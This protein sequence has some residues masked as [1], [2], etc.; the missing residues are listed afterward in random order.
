MTKS[1]FSLAAIV[2]LCLA[3][4]AP[5]T[6]INYPNDAGVI[7]VT[8]P[9][10]GL[11]PV[12]PNDGIDD[13]ANINAILAAYNYETL[14][15]EETHILA[16]WVIYFPAGTYNVSGTLLAPACSV[17]FSGAGVGATIIKLTNNTFTSAY[18]NND[19]VPSPLIQLGKKNIPNNPSLGGPAGSYANFVRNL[20]L[21]LGNNPGAAGIFTALSNMGQ[22]Y[23]VEI[24]AANASVGLLTY[25]RAGTGLI[26]NVSIEGCDYGIR[27]YWEADVSAANRY[28]TF[29]GDPTDDGLVFED[30]TIAN[31]K[32]SAIHDRARFFVMRNLTISAAP[33]TSGPAI[34]LGFSKNAAQLHV[35]GLN[36]AGNSSYPGIQITHDD[37]YLVLRDASITGC[38]KAIGYASPATGTDVTATD[39]DHYST[40]STH[41]KYRAFNKLT[42][43]LP[44]LETPVYTPPP[45]ITGNW[46]KTTMSPSNSGTANATA[47]QNDINACSTPVLYIPAGYYEMEGTIN[48]D[49]SNLKMIKGFFP[50]LWGKGATFN[51][52]DADGF[53]TIEDMVIKA[54][55]K[56]NQDMGKPL[57][58]RNIGVAPQIV[59][60]TGGRGDIFL[61]NIGAHPRIAVQG[62]IRLFARQLNREHKGLT[63]DGAVVWCLGDNIES[64]GD[65][66]TRPWKTINGGVSEILGAMFDATTP[67]ALAGTAINYLFEIDGAKSRLSVAG[68]GNYKI[69]QNKGWDLLLADK[70]G[71]DY[72]IGNRYDNSGSYVGSDYFNTTYAGHSFGE[73]IL[74]PF[75]VDR[76]NLAFYPMEDGSGPSE[77]SYCSISSVT[78]SALAKGADHFGFNAPTTVTPEMFRNVYTPDLYNTSLGL[79]D[80]AKDYAT[81]SVTPNAGYTMNIS[82]ISF[83]FAGF[84]DAHTNAFTL[85]FYIVE[86]T[87]SGFT[88]LGSY[89][90][91]TVASNELTPWQ[92]H[93]IDLSQNSGFQGLSSGK[94]FRIYARANVKH[95]RC[96]GML[97]NL[98]VHGT[99]GKRLVE[100]NF[101]ASTNPLYPSYRD[102][103]VQVLSESQMRLIHNNDLGLA[104]QDGCARILA[105]K[106]PGNLDDAVA[107]AQYLQF[108]AVAASHMNLKRLEFDFKPVAGPSPYVDHDCHVMVQ[109]SI[110]SGPYLTL[111]TFRKRF[112]SAADPAKACTFDLDLPYAQDITTVSVR[113]YVSDNQTNHQYR[114]G[115]DNLRL[116]GET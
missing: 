63:N 3:H 70:Q 82:A 97:D 87:G 114:V 36:L 51:V 100:F 32:I 115:F 61:E 73:M 54:S 110:D 98:T 28:H 38:S 56:I 9:P 17:A 12:I 62:G 80:Y 78:A 30:V 83:D 91:V 15:E 46:T 106:I 94:N 69:S 76:R 92:T 43:D 57:V 81:F 29:P 4:L 112:T 52:Q 89:A 88:P 71:Q 111:G 59:N 72:T 14:P 85:R 27:Q 67:G 22:V 10:G 53:L 35:Y 102:G 21:D 95:W 18:S 6:T 23:N 68:A 49:K 66:D 25:D 99:N 79:S 1:W 64:M 31:Y 86:D 90:E 101:N 77:T 7:D 45:A 74:P 5:G 8:N 50:I 84:N 108:T 40:F 19:Y 104:M 109:L 93:W 47:L 107:N 48:I 116:I 26:R 105:N 37:V 65:P 34:D 24:V 55:Y 41:S 11:A 33:A 58:L 13:T 113:I 44:V 39:I 75:M 103:D 60:E 42:L 96:M 20:T 2:P 16:S